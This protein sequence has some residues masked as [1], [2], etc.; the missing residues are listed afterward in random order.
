MRLRHGGEATTNNGDL[1][2]MDARTPLPSRLVRMARPATRLA[3]LALLAGAGSAHAV[4]FSGYFRA[5]PGAPRLFP[6]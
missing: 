6:P 1:D 5:G 3:A 4:D 2:P